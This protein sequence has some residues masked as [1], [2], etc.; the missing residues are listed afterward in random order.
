[1]SFN[2]AY[3][4]LSNGISTVASAAERLGVDLAGFGSGGG[5]WY[6]QLQRASF[7]GVPF[8]VLS[9][10]SQF[11]RRVAIHEYPYRDSVWVEDL[12]RAPRR[13]SLIGFLVEDSAVYGGGSVLTQRDQLQR[14]CEG[15]GEGELVHPT[16]GRKSVALLRF[17]I[18]ERFDLGRVF[19]VAFQFVEAGRLLYPG[20]TADRA[21]EIA[22]IADALGLSAVVD[23]VS[24][25]GELLR[26]GG[27]ALRQIISVVSYY[28]RMV[29]RFVNDATNLYN[30][31]RDL[32]GEFGRFFRPSN[33]R[34]G[35][36]LAAMKTSTAAARGGVSLAAIKV[37]DT[38][39]VTGTETVSATA[40]AITGH[41]SAAASA[42]PTP[43]DRLRLLAPLASDASVT[44]GSGIH[45]A[46]LYRRAA[47]AEMARAAAAWE[48]GSYD[49]AVLVR[50]RLRDVI[51]AEI[52]RSGDAG[53]DDTYLA[54]RK[55][56]A[57]VVADLTERGA[58]L[59]RLVPVAS[60]T[61]LP[62]LVLA[63]RLYQDPTRSDELVQAANPIHPAFMPTSFRALAE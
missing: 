8:G 28:V 3:R 46:A 14:A 33:S 63:Q 11:G 16:L 35:T 26:E 53:Q 1:M 43:A 48:P 39:A 38:A 2:S 44:V 27:A 20:S 61:S 15:E 5:P 37:T 62:A 36:T 58:D 30:A 10:D 52:V 56:R 25:V 41:V 6:S 19:E 59:A 54:L 50:D 4:N 47:I 55:L 31:I 23:F 22:G 21:S 34:S 12:G 7:R 9:S 57:A 49:E 60:A 42:M 51:D 18:A 40:D 29:E 45:V 17:R 13:I 24:T 32:P